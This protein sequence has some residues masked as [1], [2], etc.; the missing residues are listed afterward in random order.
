[1]QAFFYLIKKIGFYKKKAQNL[2]ICDIKVITFT[3]NYIKFRD[4]I[5][6]YTLHEKLDRNL[7][8]CYEEEG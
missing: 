1:M 6:K 5:N 8:D 3:E 2:N 4:S 7:Q